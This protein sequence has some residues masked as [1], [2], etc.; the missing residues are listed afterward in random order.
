VNEDRHVITRRLTTSLVVAATVAVAVAV[1]ATSASAGGGV[2]VSVV[3]GELTIVGT[4]RND[5]V[6]VDR[7]VAG[8]TL[9]A[10]RVSDDRPVLA[11]PGCGAGAVDT[12]VRCLPAGVTSVN[13][14]LDG[15]DDAYS[16]ATDLYAI[17]SGGDG[18]DS[19][20]MRGSAG[21]GVLSGDAGDDRI[22]A[23][24]A[25][26]MA[27]GGPGRDLIFGGS[28]RDYLSGGVDDDRL[29]GAA[30]ADVLAGGG[31]FDL[32]SYAADP[33]NVAASL[34]AAT[35]NDGHAGEGDTI[36]SD[37]EGLVGGPG[38]DYLTGNA[39]PNSLSGGPGQ[40]VLDG[41]AGAD[42]LD[43]G[44][45]TD[46]LVGGPGADVV[47]GSA[48][49]DFLLGGDHDDWLYGGSG[50]DSLVGGVGVDRCVPGDGE[51]TTTC[52]L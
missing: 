20:W 2:S 35:G 16:D 48:G 40:D 13:A 27:F 43:G 26:S 17:V 12:E 25:D 11:G 1:P 42:V 32:V 9:L 47:N 45:D 6:R 51:P 46:W 15:D 7:L 36:L 3:A 33:L 10:Y 41:A 22:F 24:N 30:G 39:D 44:D 31:G 28:G 49:N 37:V 14:R 52:E 38:H 5:F 18:H 4:G 19:I 8:T 23:G 29:D 21:F 50:W 34:D